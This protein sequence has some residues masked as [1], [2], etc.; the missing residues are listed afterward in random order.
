[1]K[2]KIFTLLTLLA[3][4]C[5]GAWADG[6]TTVTYDFTTLSSRTLASSG[7]R[8]FNG[9]ST[10]VY[11]A[12]N[13]SEFSTRFA[14]QF[15]GTFSI[16]ENGLYAQRTKGDHLGI[17]GLAAGDVVTVNF[18]AGAIMLRGAQP[19]WAGITTD[20]TNLPT[21]TAVTASVAG[22]MLMQL[23][24]SCKVT[25]ITIQTSTAETMT[26]PSISSEA[27]GDAR[28]VTIT[29]GASNLLAPV[30]TYYTTDGTTP[31]ASSTKYTGAF[32][33]TESCTINAITI[34]NSSAA[35][36]STVASETINMDAVDTPT[37]S[38]TAV[39]GIN[40]TVTFACT[41]DGA[42]LSYSTDGGSNY[43][44]ANS[45]V[46]S[47]NTSIIVKATKNAVEAVSEAYNFEAGTAITLNAPTY[48][49]GTYSAGVYTLTLNTDQTSK[50]LSPTATI[51]YSIDGG[52]EQSVASGTAV[53]VAVGS[54]LTMW[55]VA[56]GYTNSDNTVVTPTYI[57]YTTYINYWSTDFKSV[58]GSL[59][60]ETNTSLSLTKGDELVSG[61]YKITNTGFNS[62]FGVN[63]VN[64]Q[65][66]YYGA[67]KAAN[68]GLWP[69]NVT[70]Y[71]AISNLKAGSVVVFTASAAITAKANVTK[72]EFMSAAGSNYVFVVSSDGT[73]E[74]TPTKSSYVYD[75]T[76]YVPKVSGTITD[77]G[78]S[79]FSSTYPLDLSAI[80]GGTAYYASAASGTTVTLTE[81]TATV[82]A[83]E[84]LMIKGTAGETFT[85]PVV[86]SGTAIDGNLLKGQTTTG[87]VAAST[88]GTYHYVFG[89]N[90]ETPTTFGFYNLKTDTEVAAGKAY[91]ETTSALGA[92]ATI[93]LEDEVVTG[94][95][96][97]ENVE[98][99]NQVKKYLK[100]GR[101]VI[102]NANGTFSVDG[103]RIK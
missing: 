58:A 29:A 14:F 95:N 62:N 35:T 47:E 40:R 39:D 97:I 102:E 48:T 37:A 94:I 30:T 84:G 55:S 68:T 61:Y 16:D 52:T 53:N 59:L 31:T 66:R 17:V 1:M 92:R 67:T 49:I 87:D 33:V 2:K 99:S 51:S 86:A 20:W 57:D 44:T 15:A 75:V 38:I 63:D 69:Y 80:S 25:S 90:T 76:V 21:G 23:K 13:L 54:T 71:M 45:V 82:P 41:T 43:T 36:A 88:E 22:N 64:W 79:S 3:T 10:N 73:A 101:L 96:A 103:A 85:I 74:F 28:T 50:L 9:A 46:I 100:N 77:A 18:S 7:T 24:N 4:V 5:S 26:A 65:V 32:D 98:K 89:F 8:A 70:G 19:T 81:T 93:I 56:S 6:T 11:Y 12:S 83:G 72:D 42:T 78:W 91:L 34:S 60:T 27:N